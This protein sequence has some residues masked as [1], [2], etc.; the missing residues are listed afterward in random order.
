SLSWKANFLIKWNIIRLSEYGQKKRNSR[1]VQRDDE[2]KQLFY[3][4][5]GDFHYLLDIKVDEHLF[6]ALAQFWNSPYNCF[7]FEKV[8]MVPTVEEYTALLRCLRIQADKAYSRA[9]PDT[10]KKV[11]VFALSIYGLI[12]FPK[13]LGHVDK[14]VIDLFDQLDKRVTP[15]P[16]ILAETF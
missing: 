2:V 13:A 8:D 4:N 10:R 5:Y 1:K 3:C 14:A 12:I 15:V 7:T 6:R 9:H 16:A 11:D